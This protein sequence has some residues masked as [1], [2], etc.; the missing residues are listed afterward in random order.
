MIEAT[1]VWA[2]LK[3]QALPSLNAAD[4]LLTLLAQAHMVSQMWPK[5][6]ALKYYHQVAMSLE[7]GASLPKCFN[8]FGTQKIGAACVLQDLEW[9]RIGTLEILHLT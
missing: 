4:L 5:C 8:L 7:L 2:A 9:Q 3:H 1:F 6:P